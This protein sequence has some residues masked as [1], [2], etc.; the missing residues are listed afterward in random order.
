MVRGKL[1]S[2]VLIGKSSVDHVDGAVGDRGEMLVVGDDD[3]GL[4]EL[5]AQVEEELV[6]LCFVLGVETT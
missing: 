5:V 3:K 2:S 4:S 6:E 1:F